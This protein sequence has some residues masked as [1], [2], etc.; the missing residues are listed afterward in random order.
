MAEAKTKKVNKGLEA[1][2]KKRAESKFVS[3]KEFDNLNDSVSQLVDMVQ[4]VLERPTHTLPLSPAEVKESKE[5]EA[6]GPIKYETNAEW[7]AM[8]KEIIGTP[9][10]HTEV[11][12]LKGGGRLFTIVIKREHSN[13]NQ[14]YLERYQVDRRSKEI[15]AEGEA[16]VE[17]WCKL[18]LNNLK[19]ANKPIVDAR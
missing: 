1:I 14:D 11:K 12:D 15:G 2:A 3:K 19:R 16:G 10:D 17:N 9:V 8:A 18:V 5:I 7:D 4:K 13:A 6:A